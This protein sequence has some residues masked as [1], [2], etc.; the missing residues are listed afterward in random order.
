MR[1]FE[2]QCN[3]SEMN[4]LLDGEVTNVKWDHEDTLSL[5]E[6]SFA[7]V[8]HVLPTAIVNRI[9]SEFDLTEEET[10][11]LADKIGVCITKTGGITD[12]NNPHL[13]YS[14]HLRNE[15]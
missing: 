6:F 9:N 3:G 12:Y 4:V 1:N 7:N 13:G 15:K 11:A 8:N 10:L 14:E 5:N 2:V